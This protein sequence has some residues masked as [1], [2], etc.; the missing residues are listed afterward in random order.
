MSN[1]PGGALTAPTDAPAAFHV[2]AKPTG[3]ICNLDCEYCFFLSKEML[4]P[5]DRFRMADDLLVT[6]LRQLLESHRTPEVTVVWQGG[7]PTMMG[8]DF[9]RRVV[10][11][12]EEFRRPNQKVLHTIQTNATLLDDEWAAFFKEHEFLVGVSMDGPKDI[13]DTYRVD[14]GGKGSFDRVMKGFNALKRH[15]VDVNILCTIHDANSD[16]GLDVYRFFRDELGVNF[17]QFIPI[18]ERVTEEEKDVANLGWS[19]GAGKDRPLYTISGNEVTNR[20]VPP[21]G[22]G[23]FMIDVFDEWVRKDVGRVYVQFFD[24]S[25]ESWYGQKQSLCILSETCGTAVAME[26]NG[27]L[28]SCDHYVEPDY[29][30]GNIKDVPMIELIS[31]PRQKAFGDA[32]RDTLPQYC[33]DCEVKFACNGG[34]PRNR[35]TDT[36]DG[37]PGLNYLCPSYKAFFKHIDEPMRYMAN[38]LKA[39]RAPAEIMQELANR[40]PPYSGV[41]RNDVCPCGSGKKF[42]KC[43]GATA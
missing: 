6:Y 1:F 41:R 10:E 13:H 33:R 11:L 32:K 19:T 37:E 39:G 29:L 15:E 9:F 21:D 17:L 18:V 28:Y 3:P 40:P 38:L 24:V 4:Y 43:H 35:F 36:P 14:K 20:S 2:M 26:H 34:C 30:L 12:S 16:R 27:D 22:F 25:L 23:H 8:L 5:G 31:S 42:K 7:E